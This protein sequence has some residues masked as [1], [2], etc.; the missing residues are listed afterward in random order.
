MSREFREYR[1]YRGISEFRREIGKYVDDAQVAR[2]EQYVF[3]PIK[4]NSA[5]DAHLRTI[6]GLDDGILA[7]IKQS[8]PFAGMEDFR[9][10]VRHPR[11]QGGNSSPGTLPHHRI[12]PRENLR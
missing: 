6:P 3:V 7:V 1:P 9:G 4:L 10:R 11:R 2:F 5:G 12:E 8:R